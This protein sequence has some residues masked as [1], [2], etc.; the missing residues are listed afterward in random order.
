MSDFW[1]AQFYR[2][3]QLTCDHA[4]SWLNPLSHHSCGVKRLYCTLNWT[5]IDSIYSIN[6]TEIWGKPIRRL[7]RACGNPHVLHFVNVRMSIENWIGEPI[8]LTGW[9]GCCPA[10][11]FAFQQ[12]STLKS[13]RISKVIVNTA[14]QTQARTIRSFRA[15][16]IE[17]Y[18]TIN[19]P[20]YFKSLLSL[21]IATI[22]SVRLS[23]YAA[24]AHSGDKDSL[25]KSR[26]RSK[27]SMKK[28]SIFLHLRPPPPLSLCP[29]APSA[30]CTECGA[31]SKMQQQ[32]FLCGLPSPLVDH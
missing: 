32:R 27:I 5:P 14:T 2:S 26:S 21:P 3:M 30:E 23:F 10:V 24:P 1:C 8:K 22:P 29:S 18:I 11:H 20:D 4:K 28:I 13:I 17:I 9:I 12:D 6:W 15:A 19:I 25:F 7:V 31:C 16:H